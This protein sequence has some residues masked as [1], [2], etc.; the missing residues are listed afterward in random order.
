MDA[1]LLRFNSYFNRKLIVYDQ[2][3]QYTA[4]SSY[5]VAYNGVNF[6]PGDGVSAS[7]V[8]GTSDAQALETFYYG[9][10]YAVMSVTETPVG[11]STP[12]TTIISRW[13]VMRAQ[14][15]RNGQYELTLRRDVLAD[16]YNKV[17]NSPVFV[18]KAIITDKSDPLLYN[19]ESMGF[20][21]IKISET[22]LKDDTG[23]GWVVGY[24]PQDAFKDAP[25]E[26][27]KDV[28]YNS[29]PD[30]TVSGINSWAYYNLTQ[31][32]NSRVMWTTASSP[33]K[34]LVIKTRCKDAN[35][36]NKVKGRIYVE[37]GGGNA[38]TSIDT[39]TD[40]WDF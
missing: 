14:R 38:M 3:S 16:N 31:L 30:Y 11:S 35:G 36:N 12:V 17:K 29:T 19:S 23:C 39:S 6:N 24:I 40:A 20:N 13:F 34:Q 8:I 2:L 1:N 28:S 33:S 25:K 9:L 37:Q 32:S 21:Q 27:S 22:E 10:D 15:L 4:A 7:L 18:E 26:I 5:S